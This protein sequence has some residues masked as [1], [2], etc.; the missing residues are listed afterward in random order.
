MV[1]YALLIPKEVSDLMGINSKKSM[2]CMQG[3]L[4]ATFQMKM[5]LHGDKKAQKPIIDPNYA[6]NPRMYKK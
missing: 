3:N 2:E 5:A 1:P 4:Q 6:E